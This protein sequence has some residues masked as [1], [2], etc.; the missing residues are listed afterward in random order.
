M[1]DISP[2]TDQTILITGGTGSFGR[3]L[4]RHLLQENVCRKVIIFSRDEW[5]QWEMRRS[6]PIFD[7]PKIRYF[8]GDVRDAPRLMRAFHEVDLIVHAA[9]LKQVPAAE[10]NPSEFI[11][12]NINGAMNVINAAIDCGVKKVIA[13]ST[14]KAVNPVNLYGATKLCSDK[15]FVAGNAYVGAKGFPKFAVVRYG[16]V[17]GSRG[18]IIPFWQKLIDQGVEALPITDERM[19]RFWITLE[20]TVQFVRYCFTHIEGGEIFVPKIPSIKI[21]D[22]AEAMAPDLPKE[23]C[24]IRP[25][26]KLN[27]LMISADDS[28]HT[29]ELKNHYIILPEL[30]QDEP[31]YTQGPRCRIRGTPVAAGFVYASHTNTEWLSVEDIRQFLSGQDFHEHIL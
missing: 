8:L 29:V 21:M 9:A 16:N 2:F 1:A 27:E 22:L 30:A 6:A 18:S 13:L 12:T 26:E 20:Q 7:H 31:I 28:R 23:F 3:A 11:K 19:T 5:K 4:T 17:A 15:L 10:Y 25:G 14:D 24:G